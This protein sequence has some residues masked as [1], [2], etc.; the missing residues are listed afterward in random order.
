MK[1]KYLFWIAVIHFFFISRVSAQ[2]DLTVEREMSI[3]LIEERPVELIYF[4]GTSDQDS[5]TLYW[6]TA[7]EIINFGFEVQRAYPDTSEWLPI[8]FVLGAGTSFSPRDYIFG[9]STVSD[10]GIYF[11]RLKQIDT[12]GDFKYSWT[13]TV[14]YLITEVKESEFLPG[15]FILEQNYPNPFNPNTLISFTLPRK[16]DVSLRIYSISGELVE[17]LVDEVMYAGNYRV[18]FNA[19]GIASGIYFYSLKTFYGIQTKKMIFLK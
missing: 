5:V 17:T 2:P 8:G 7:T 9:D 12:N 19:G 14:P 3:D 1:L 16:S 6:G 13:I 18:T 10:S 4:Y 15:D 11:Y